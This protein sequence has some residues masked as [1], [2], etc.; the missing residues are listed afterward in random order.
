MYIFEL[1]D[2][3]AFKAANPHA[4]LEDFVRWHS[5]KDWIED[6]DSNLPGCLSSR[7]SEPSNIWQELWKVSMSSSCMINPIYRLI[8]FIF[9]FSLVRT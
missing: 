9:Y 3:Q 2:M 6:S 1:V 8:H 5:P 4:V 7:M